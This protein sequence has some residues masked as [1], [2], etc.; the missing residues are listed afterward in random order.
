MC[1]VLKDKCHEICLRRL[2][3][4]SWFM[5]GTMKVTSEREVVFKHYESPKKKK[6]RKKKLLIRSLETLNLQFSQ[7]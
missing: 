1:M 4:A 5:P 3:I 6:E 2:I 7:L